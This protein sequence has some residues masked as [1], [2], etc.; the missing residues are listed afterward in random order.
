MRG[1]FAAD[2]G[3]EVAAKAA[4]K[5]ASYPVFRALC[6][7]AG[8][9]VVDTENRGYGLYYRLLTGSLSGEL[10][11]TEAADIWQKLLLLVT[12]DPLVTQIAA[13]VQISPT[14]LRG[15]WSSPRGREM[16]RQI[17][18]LNLH[19]A[20]LTRLPLRL[21]GYEKFRQDLLGG[22]PSPEQDEIL[23]QAVL[24]FSDLCFDAK[25]NKV[26]VFSLALAWKGT[27][28][29]LGWGSIAPVLPA[30][31]RGPL[32]YGLGLRYLKLNKPADAR[33]LFR[34]AVADAPADSS[35]A[36]LAAEEL[37][38]LDKKP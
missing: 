20:E 31:V 14:V 25:L 18:F 12:D 16:A 23:W 38:R 13:T 5:N 32:A 34:T 3:D 21:I 7:A 4:W 6:D 33:M 36:R 22:K 2:K 37:A 15:M 24:R 19:P 29:A 8:V 30:D 28:G 11:D 9:R 10:T 35:L 17:T 26:Q 27:S 1:F